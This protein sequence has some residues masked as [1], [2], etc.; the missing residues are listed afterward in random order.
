MCRTLREIAAGSLNKFEYQ[1]VGGHKY[2]SGV[3]SSFDYRRWDADKHQSCVCD[4]GFTGP[5]CSQR[6]CPRGDDPLTNGARWCG[7]AACTWEVQSFTVSDTG[8][9]TYRIGYT[10]AFNGT[11][12]TYVTVDTSSGNNGYVAPASQSSFLPGPL[13]IAGQIM[14][15]LRSL[16]GGALQRVEV[17]P[18]G[19]PAATPGSDAT[20]TFAITFVGVSG[21]VAPLS[22]VPV[23]ASASVWYNPDSPLYNAV[24]PVEASRVVV[25]VANGN[26]E[27]FE[28]SGR[29][30]CDRTAG[31]C[32]CFPGYT[33][34][35]CTIQD[36]LPM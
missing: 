3:R 24:T 26:Y 22:V 34:E 15:A 19:D 25:E 31:L 11:A 20:R 14:N 21:N 10:D 30:L 12:F 18:R 36:A 13:T 29:G 9:A 16:P 2:F 28:C 6:L 4:P 8:N 33:G 1:S 27:A 32:K 35:S 7:G 23:T 5:D 17:F